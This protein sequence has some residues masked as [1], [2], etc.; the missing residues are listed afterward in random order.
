MLATRDVEI[1]SC[2]I[3]C[4]YIPVG[5]LECTGN[6]WLIAGI[7]MFVVVWYLTTLA[8]W[9]VLSFDLAEAMPIYAAALGYGYTT[10]N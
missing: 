6:L 5:L 3:V 10:H 2:S 4:V 7:W 1:A 8:G 9:V